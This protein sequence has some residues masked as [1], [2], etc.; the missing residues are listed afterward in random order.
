MAPWV[1][2]LIIACFF[3]VLEIFT[4]GFLV[5]WLGIA[6]VFALIFSLVFPKLIIGQ[7]IVWLILSVILILLTKKFADKITSTT[8]PTNVYSVIGKKANV[9]AEINGEKATGQIKVDGDIWAAKTEEFNEVI[10][11]G[12]I[13]EVV[14]IDG[15]KVVVKKSENI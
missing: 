4:S 5:I 12:T 9:I 15:V 6:A 7:A 14:R 3:I 8:T 13:V 1:I 10:P 2:W 11:V